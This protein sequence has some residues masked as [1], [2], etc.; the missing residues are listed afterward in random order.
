MAQ[1]TM[2]QRVASLPLRRHADVAS[3]RKLGELIVYIASC[4]EDDSNFGSTIL[5]KT[6][7]FADCIA[8]T[9]RG[10]SITGAQY[11]KETYGPVPVRFLPV[12]EQ[13]EE[14]GAIAIQERAF[15]KGRQRRIVP[16]REPQLDLFRPQ[17]IAL[18]DKIIKTL[19][20][21]T[22]KSISDFTHDK[23]PWKLAR[24]GE[25]IPYSAIVLSEDGII[26][27]DI[28]EAQELIKRHGWTDV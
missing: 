20:T 13:L 12:K 23:T 8:F 22:A 28:S 24:H 16:L 25:T 14:A 27:S 6:L 21:H 19:R 11:M 26:E 2:Q 18:V 17:D 15:F 1:R 9:E 7:Y 10:E 5:N 3:D 4:C